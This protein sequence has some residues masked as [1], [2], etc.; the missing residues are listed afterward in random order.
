M[1]LGV[2]QSK[3]CVQRLT[4]SLFFCNIVDLLVDELCIW[5]CIPHLQ[6]EDYELFRYPLFTNRVNSGLVHQLLRK[7]SDLRLLD[8]LLLSEVIWTSSS[9]VWRRTGSIQDKWANCIHD[10]HTNRT[11]ADWPWA[12]VWVGCSWWS[13]KISQRRTGR[14]PGSAPGGSEQASQTSSS[15]SC[16][17]QKGPTTCRQASLQ[18][19]LYPTCTAT[20]TS[21]KTD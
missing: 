7:I 3:N 18:L 17:H 2:E 12:L 14:P 10:K 21:Q 13:C 1:R 11:K 16:L 4:F 15:Y 6:K 8:V 19:S 9:A 20:T 5:C